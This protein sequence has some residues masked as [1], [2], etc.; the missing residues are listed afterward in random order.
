VWFEAA[1]T[2]IGLERVAA[3][4]K[5]AVRHI[6]LRV[7]GFDRG[8]AAEKLKRARIEVVASDETQ[9]IRFRDP[10]GFVTELRAG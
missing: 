4:E 3:G 6:S 8:S 9:T 5:P 2:K 7:A 1:R 10:N